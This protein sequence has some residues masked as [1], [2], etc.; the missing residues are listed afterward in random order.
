MLDAC[1]N[2]VV[3]ATLSTMIPLVPVRLPDPAYEAFTALTIELPRMKD[4]T[5]DFE[6]H[7]GVTPRLSTLRNSQSVDVAVLKISVIGEQFAELLVVV[8]WNGVPF[9]PPNAIVPAMFVKPTRY[10]SVIVPVESGPQ[11]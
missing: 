4:M 5:Q 9:V 1:G 2:V 6:L 8:S 11:T 10:K 3:L 7:V